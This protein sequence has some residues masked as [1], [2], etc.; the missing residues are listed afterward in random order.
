MITEKMYRYLGRN[1]NIT[2]HVK[3]ETIDPIPMINL[4]ASTGK[5][6]TDGI[7]KVYS[8]IVFEDE[9]NNWTEIDDS[10]GQK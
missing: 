6:L 2:T 8:V 10:V 7:K 1:G 5:I 4:K 9:I 3:L